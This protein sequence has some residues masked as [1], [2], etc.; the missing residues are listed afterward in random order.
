MNTL[1]HT[2]IE[3]EPNS[4]CDQFEMGYQFYNAKLK[5]DIGPYKSGDVIHVLSFNIEES[6][7]QIWDDNGN[8]LYSHPIKLSLA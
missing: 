7:I 1:F 8:E 4:F 3:D 6:R 5:I 2:I